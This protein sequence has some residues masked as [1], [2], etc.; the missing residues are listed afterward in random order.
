MIILKIGFNWNNGILEYWGQT[1][2]YG[3]VSFETIIPLFHHSI[4]SV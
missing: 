3:I 2:E 4:F 1:E